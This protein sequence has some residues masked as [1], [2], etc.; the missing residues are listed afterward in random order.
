MEIAYTTPVN[1][2]CKIKK[3]EI[4]VTFSEILLCGW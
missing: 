3:W 1:Q 4:I 2:Y